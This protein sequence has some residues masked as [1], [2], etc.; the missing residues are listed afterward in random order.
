MVLGGIARWLKPSRARGAGRTRGAGAAD[1]EGRWVVIDVETSGLDPARDVVLSIG[2]VAVH[3]AA[4][5]VADS[6]ELLVR[7]QAASPRQNILVHGIGEAAQLGGL[8]PQQACGRFLDYVG[9]APLVAFHAEFDRAFL[10]RAVRQHCGTRLGNPWLDLAELAPALHPQ[11]RAKA[12]DA[13]LEHFGIVVEQRH[14]ACSDAFA[15][16]MLFV[17]L[18]AAV[19]PAQRTPAALARRARDARW[20]PAG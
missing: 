2:A 14:D 4:I 9:D 16:A 15:T 1:A 13:W 12:L 7:P 3:G 20:L 10:A 17:R 8:D 19:A 18:L 11:V 5:V 6:F